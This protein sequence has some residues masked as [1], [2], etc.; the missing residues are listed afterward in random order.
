MPRSPVRLSKAEDRRHSRGPRRGE[1]TADVLA[2]VLDY[3]PEQGGGVTGEGRVL[4]AA[5]E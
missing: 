1:H 5:D 4:S 2:D 3:S